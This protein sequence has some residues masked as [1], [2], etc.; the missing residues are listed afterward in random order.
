MAKL[1]P[2]SLI[3]GA[4]GS[5]GTTTFSHNRGGWYSKSR[6]APTNPSSTAQQN[7][8]NAVKFASQ[9]WGSTLSDAQRLQWET[10]AKN[11][12]R[13]NSVGQPITMT[14]ANCF[15]WL[16]TYAKWFVSSSLGAP[17]TPVEYSVLNSLTIAG[18]AAGTT[19]DISWD[20]DPLDT[21]TL[22]AVFMSRPLGAGRSAPDGTWS[23]IMKVH[24][25][26]GQP[27]NVWANYVARYGTPVAGQKTFWRAWCMRLYTYIPTPY[28]T[29][30]FTWGA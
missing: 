14:G 10:F 17:P 19:L 5:V 24:A 25:D 13:T 3:N 2:G 11:F 21:T 12:P 8:R 16:C 27:Q 26:F 7:W 15:M 28:L 20:T 23:N 29:G 9:L 18:S 4:S 30:F 6:V 22:L 1:V